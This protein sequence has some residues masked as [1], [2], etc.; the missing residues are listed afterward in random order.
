MKG[1]RFVELLANIKANIV[2]F[3]SISMFVALGVGLFLGIQWGAV[4]LRNVCQEIVEANNMHDIEITFP[5]GITD[6]DIAQIKKIEGVSHVETGYSSFASMVDGS[7]NYTLKMQTLPGDINRFSKVTGNLPM[8]KNELALL[9][10]WAEEKNL[11]I[12]DVVKFKHDA[13][14]SGDEDGMQYLNA[15]TFTIT[16]IVETPQYIQNGSNTLGLSNV[17]PGT[18][19]CVA[20]VPEA[21]VDTSK[22]EGG[23][24]N[25]Y[26][27]CDSLDGVFTFKDEYLD[28]VNP[29]VSKLTELGSVL[30]TARY[31]KVHGDA[32]KKIDDAQKTIDDGEKAIEDG[33]KTIEDGEEALKNGREEL[34]DGEKALVDGATVGAAQQTA[35]N[36][37]LNDGYRQLA[38]GQ[39]KYDAGMQTYTD[40]MDLLNQ[41][42][43][44]IDNG[45]DPDTSELESSVGDLSGIV[46]D[47][48]SI[49]IPTGLTN[50]DMGDNPEGISSAETSIDLDISSADLLGNLGDATV[51]VRGTE[52]SLNDL[53]G[54]IASLAQTLVDSKQ[55]LDDAKAKLDA[56]WAEYYKNK[57]AYDE[58]VA[59]GNAKLVSG[60]QQ[61]NNGRETL[62]EKEKALEDGKQTLAEKEKALEDGKADFADAKKQFDK[63][64]EYEWVVLSRMDNGGMQGVKTIY[65]M[66]DSVKWAMA[67]LFV[68]VG[69][70]VCYSAIS[71]L[72]HEQITQIGTKKAL[73]FRTR[74]LE[75]HYLLFSGIGVVLGVL[76]CIL[77]AVFLVQGIMN[78]KAAK[79]FSVPMYAPYINVLDIIIIGGI[80]LIL[81][82]LST[83][84]AMRGMLKR[85]AV[86]LLR[87]ES[88]GNAKEHFYEHWAIW[89]RMSLFS[90]TVVNNCINDKR[91]VV[92]TLIGVIGCTALIVVAVTLDVNVAKSLDTHYDHVYHFDTLAYLTEG[93]QEVADEVAM[94]L[95]KRGVTSAPAYMVKMQVRQNDDTRSVATLVVPT[96]EDSFKKF[97][98]VNSV[99]GDDAN[100]ENGGIWVSQAYADHKGAKVGDEITV[101]EVSGKA[102]KFRIAGFFEYYLLR[103]E[104]VL[105]PREYREAFGETPAPNV[106]MVNMDHADLSRTRD[107]LADIDG[108]Q[109]LYDDFDDASYAYDELKEILSTVVLIYLALSALMAIVVLLNLDTMFVDEKKRELIVLMING[110]T[111]KQAK[112]YI[113][114]DSIVLTIIGIILGV[115]LGAIMGGITVMALEP[116]LGHWLRGF[117][118]FA[119]IVGI[120]GAGVFAAAVLLWALR[121]IPKFNLI[122]INRF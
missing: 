29:I 87:G 8:E 64:I 48:G 38:D 66:M 10:F 41:V 37:K 32:Q 115:L 75:T 101:T 118:W 28:G 104:F 30:G 86:D 58:G 35:A 34:A 36:T 74:E 111:V 103:Q 113:Y 20:Y 83:W 17:G 69:L 85:H 106:L 102:H 40:T 95:Y 71:R 70:F 7:T 110:F 76:L 67:L 25:V 16:A 97:Y 99:S 31:N 91:R 68:L 43:A 53:P 93:N 1:I 82:L 9:S 114:R 59:D 81:I 108:F 46:G 21:S 92:G 96:S 11:G 12:G 94:R 57:A 84:F 112:A 45:E 47:L 44:Q 50:S 100:V 56:G 77:L 5:Y 24:P 14:D 107:A 18:I 6:D 2:A 72:V 26:I 98:S 19:D 3:I 79:Q 13:I 60:Q 116:D 120:V 33:R 61:I 15:D 27:T 55:E 63:L 119:A 80:E 51:N 73:G 52:I 105:S 4:A 109:M 122:D 88:M 23:Y 39:A 22:Y 78:P 54:G 62:A 121:R 117:S 90:Q 42:L 49:S 65:S 89:Q